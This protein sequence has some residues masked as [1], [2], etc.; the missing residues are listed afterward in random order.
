MTSLI[1][2]MPFMG[3]A[4]EEVAA[5]AADLLERFGDEA[6]DEAVRLEQVCAEIRSPRNQ[7]LYRRA[8]REISK[9]F[10]AVRA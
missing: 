10:A 8:A 1:S 6:L 2:R 9:S 3:P 7:R 5:A 4:R